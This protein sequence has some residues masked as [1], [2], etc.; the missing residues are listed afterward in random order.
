MLC[1]PCSLLWA[2]KEEVDR[3]FEVVPCGEGATSQVHVE[4]RKHGPVA[5]KVYKSGA[6]AW[7]EVSVLR[8]LGE[9]PPCLP[10]L[11]HVGEDRIV[12]SFVGTRNLVEWL[13]CPWSP[14][15]RG[16]CDRIALDVAAALDHMH[17]RRIAHLDVKA[18]NVV[19]RDDG[20]ATLVDFDLSHAYRHDESEYS[21]TCRRGSVAYLP[22]EMVWARGGVSGF[23]ADAWSYGIVFVAL[24]YKR[25]PFHRASPPCELF[26]RFLLLSMTN[27]PSVALEKLHPLFGA[28]GDLTDVHRR[29]V[30]AT[31]SRRPANRASFTEIVD[32]IRPLVALAPTARRMDGRR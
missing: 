18:D 21:L 10:H 22:P 8:R 32:T 31:M 15:D 28:R 17:R 7:H 14:A 26:R 6:V 13:R 25:V 2:E 24:C 9:R 23:R 12:L 4:H 27:A 29:V 3:V 1:V 19:V 16:G 30:D 11:L 5:V 20:R